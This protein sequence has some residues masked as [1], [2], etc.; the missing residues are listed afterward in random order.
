MNASAEST[1]LSFLKLSRGDVNAT[2]YMFANIIANSMIPVFLLIPIG[3]SLEFSMTHLVPGFAVGFLVGSGGMIFSAFRLARKER[4]VDITAH[5]YGNNVPAMVAYTL[6]ITMPIFLQTQDLILAWGVTAAAVI[7]TGV[8]KLIMAPFAKTIARLI[9]SPAIMTVFGAAMYTYLAMV[10]LPRLFDNPLVALIALSIVM[11]TELA[12]IPITKKRFPSLLFIWIIPLIVAIAIGYV[13]PQWHGI[14]FTLPLV[15][16]LEP[17]FGIGQALNYLALIVP[18]AF[19]LGLQCI[20]SVQGGKFA[21]DDYHAGEILAWDGLGTIVTGLCGGTAAPCIYAIHPP[22]KHQ[23]GAKI[24]YT[25]W[26]PVLYLFIIVIGLSS[27]FASLFPWPI[28]T[29]M[30]MFA[31]IGVGQATFS[32]VPPKYFPA[33]LLGLVMPV[34]VIVSSTVTTALPALGLSLAS[35]EVFAALNTSIYWSSLQGLG[36]SFL[37]LVMFVS[38]IITMLI[39][40]RFTGA[41]IWCLIAAVFSWIGLLHS[42]AMSWGAQPLYT[43]GWAVAALIIFSAK[44]WRGPD[45]A[46]APSPSNTPNDTPS[47]AK[48]ILD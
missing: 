23:M 39:D 38:T 7:L 13:I 11:I 16:S 40:R 5:P 27:T 8:I 20:A 44:W 48:P 45:P 22:L 25:F 19:Y 46:P 32:R 4:R 43:I 1:K 10:M 35:P 36:N 37:L 3:I 33:L 18:M 2:I 9:P 47:T 6:G 21:G 24:S 30:I 12:K 31:A 26:A 28:L 17:V 14:T 29:S 15:L 41:A 42:A 34:G